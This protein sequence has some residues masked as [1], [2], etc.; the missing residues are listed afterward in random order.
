MNS[1]NQRPAIPW[2]LIILFLVLSAGELVVGFLYYRHQ[3]EHMLNDTK[4]ELSAIAD[5]KVRQLSQWRL[6]RIKDGNSLSQNT[7]TITQF[8]EFLK[9]P[10]NGK[11]RSD[12][13][14]NLK[15]LVDNYDY[16]SALFA[17][18]NL[19]VKLAYPETDSIIGDLL[20]K[21]LKVFMDRG[22]VIITD[23]HNVSQVN[24]PHLDL[25]IPLK[26]SDKD[27]GRV[28]GAV[29]LR[30]DPGDVLFPLIRTWPLP[31]KTSEAYLVRRE[32]DEVIYFSRL[33][34]PD[35]TGMI[36][37]S[38][39]EEKL[40]G[41]M[42]IQGIQQTDDA[43]DYRGVKVVAAMKKVP[44]LPWFMVAKTD[45]DEILGALN[46]EMSQIFMITF[47][48]ILITALLFG[49]LW[50]N[51]RVRFYRGRYEME[52]E[53]L[54]LVRHFDYILRYANDVI[55][56]FNKG[57][58][59]IEANDQALEK[60]QYDRKELIG[61]KLKD[62]LPDKKL[63][64]YRDAISK[65]DNVGYHTF[66][67]VH[68]R[69]DGTSFPVEISARRILMEGL[70]YYQTIGR[71]ITERKQSEEILKESE[72][73][74][75]KIFEESP[76]GMAMTG[77]DLVIIR[78]NSAFCKMMGYEEK[79]LAGLTFKSF[80]PPDY[81][82]RDEYELLRLIANEIPIYHTEN[83]Y[84]RK[85]GS[86]IWGSTTVSIIRN[87][88][89][90]V[91]FFLGMVEDVTSRKISEAELIAAKEKA[92]ESD[93]LKTAFLHNISHEIRTPMNAILGFSSLLNEPG[94]TESEKNQY[95][96][97]IFQSGNQL[98]SIIN[99]IVDLAG[100]ESGQVKI[101]IGRVNINSLLRDLSEQYAYKVKVQNV[102]LKLAVSLPNGDSEIM[103]DE[104]RLIQILSNLINNAFKFTK[105]GK[106]DFGYDLKNGFLEFYV[107]DTGIGIPQEFHS[108]IF[109]RFYQVDSTVSRQYTGTGL[110]LSICKAYVGLLGGNI[111]VTSKQ[112]SGSTFWF[113]IPYVKE[114]KE[115][116]QIQRAS[117]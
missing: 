2:P 99:D 61:K 98:L 10:N 4:E 25:I 90:E 107:K 24:Y 64:I 96:D 77:K 91:Q 30:I 63:D 110:G 17:D 32:G 15:S 106:I 37:K 74:F 8:A 88:N 100:I 39:T 56:L 40:A 42:A 62:L 66:E 54:A 41:A 21:S 16:A 51:Q 34:Y 112:G 102:G 60:Y 76:I 117:Q 50:W 5:L 59:I 46:I 79:E 94:V 75:R 6:E 105:K 29:I 86:V 111:W 26:K 1:Q 71:D 3:R 89:D 114:K 73:K 101:K 18:R 65:L 28:F 47:L 31:G 78:A 11:L 19:K 44:E 52:L 93:R 85:D 22:D 109:E 7:S 108:L 43:V 38:I 53:H 103:T 68:K 13:S 67:V 12:L 80:T 14:G 70:V 36:R 116:T 55:M 72:E 27:D 48:F 35:S 49:L 82:A 113:T 87:N 58:E 97:I 84:I 69:K 23:I 95:I 45:R 57:L 20:S 33:K 92:E 9:D 81:T 115:Q 104:T 83:Q